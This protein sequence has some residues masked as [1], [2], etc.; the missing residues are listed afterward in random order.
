MK[1]VL[2]ATVV[3]VI[4]DVLDLNDNLISRSKQDMCDENI[5]SKL[6]GDITTEV[7]EECF[8][9]NWLEG[10]GKGR[11]E[12]SLLENSDIKVEVIEE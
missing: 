9:D 10:R 4:D 2:T 6:V 12:L 5:G 3:V 11:I 1:L 7:L 8:D